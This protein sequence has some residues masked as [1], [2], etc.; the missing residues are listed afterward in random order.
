[1][2]T[3]KFHKNH[4]Y[5]FCSYIL[6]VIIFFIK[7]F[8]ASTVQSASN[9]DNMQHLN[10]LSLFE[11]D[12]NLSPKFKS[13]LDRE[14]NARSHWLLRANSDFYT[15]GLS[16]DGKKF[17]GWADFYENGSSGK[18][19]I[20]DRTY[21]NIN[22][23]EC[24]F[25]TLI[26]NIERADPD[27]WDNKIKAEGEFILDCPNK[28]IIT[29]SWYQFKEKGIFL[30]NDKSMY[31]IFVNNNFYSKNKFDLLGTYLLPEN[32]FSSIIAN[33]YHETIKLTQSLL[34]TTKLTND[35]YV[36]DLL[37]RISLASWYYFEELKALKESKKNINIASPDIITFSKNL[38]PSLSQPPKLKKRVTESQKSDMTMTI[39]EID[40][41]RQQLHSCLNLNVGVANLKEIKPVIFIEVNPDRTVKSARVVQQERLN[42]LSFRTAAEAAM[43][44]VNNPNCS[45]LFLPPNK[46]DLWKEINFTFDFSWM[47]D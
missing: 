5:E 14:L 33:D 3:K 23:S 35:Y 28:S 47:F 17:F 34:K 26:H 36:N 40:L 32:T 4:H 27:V 9:W 11:R 6:L 39:S 18:A 42:E 2:N 8:F 43:R 7:I 25:N 29:G 30:S 46:Y 1:M 38:N 10:D 41:L 37:N 12:E 21:E 13:N 19:Y 24:N 20:L 44:A 15:L 31:G 22:Q 45:P 16:K